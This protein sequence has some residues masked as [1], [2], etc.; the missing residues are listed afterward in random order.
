MRSRNDTY[1]QTQTALSQSDCKKWTK[2]FVLTAALKDLTPKATR[3][4]VVNNDK[5]IIMS[6]FL[7]RIS[8]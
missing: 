3:H 4:W 5:I 8:K 7:G 6:I 1:K 2:T